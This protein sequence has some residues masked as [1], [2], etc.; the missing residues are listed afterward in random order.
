MD[1]V[2]AARGHSADKRSRYRVVKDLRDAGIDAV[3]HASPPNFYLHNRATGEITSSVT[4]DGREALP[5]SMG[6][7]NR[8][9]V[10]CNENGQ[11]L[12]YDSDERG[13]RNPRG[14]WTKVPPDVVLLGD[15]FGFG[16]CEEDGN[17]IAGPIRRQIPATLNL[18][19]SGGGGLSMLAYLNEYLVHLRPRH[20]FWLF[21]EG[22]D[23]QNISEDMR[24]P[25]LRRYLDDPTFAVGLM[26]RQAEVDLA[27]QVL[28]DRFL[29][30]GEKVRL[31]SRWRS[32]LF[33]GPL[34]KA[35]DLPPITAVWTRPDEDNLALPELDQALKRMKTGVESW[36]GRLHLV[37]LPAWSRGRDVNRVLPIY[38][39]TY[40]GVRA[41]SSA[42]GINFIDLV[43]TFEAAAMPERLVSYPTSHYND[44][45][46]RLVADAI[47]KELGASKP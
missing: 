7:S 43:P 44:R 34:R 37:Y 46:Y 3:P 11:W 23:M 6:V 47:L 8:R 27:A 1:E 18:S 45:G 42:N 17:D 24:M 29:E 12:I 22:N 4:I 25:L 35:L 9:T 28:V 31:E 13:F 40:Q 19:A 32:L 41:I 21:F 39:R 16:S 30:A 26:N 2:A 10:A 38:V 36:G 14:S 5:L 20:V 15:S 33:L